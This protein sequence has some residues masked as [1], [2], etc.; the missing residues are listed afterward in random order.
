MKASVCASRRSV[1]GPDTERRGPRSRTAGPCTAAYV[2]H[3]RI[4]ATGGRQEASLDELIES[5]S[6][7]V[8]RDRLRVVGDEWMVLGTLAQLQVADDITAESHEAVSNALKGIAELLERSRAYGPMQDAPLGFVLTLISAMADATI[9]EMIRV[10][11]QAE[12]YSRLA[13][14]A[15]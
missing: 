6:H 13:F 1:S 9:D 4:G 14:D 5:A 7:I 8:E 10:P 12:T 3:S 11:A 15:I 2:G